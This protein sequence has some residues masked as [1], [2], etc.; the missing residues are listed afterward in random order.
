MTSFGSFCCLVFEFVCGLRLEDRTDF[1]IRLLA[2]DDF[3]FR[4]Y[5][6]SAPAKL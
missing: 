4:Y 5:H 3:S 6:H 2:E 1:D